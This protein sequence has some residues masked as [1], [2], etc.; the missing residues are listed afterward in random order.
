[1]RKCGVTGDG[2]APKSQ[3]P[4]RKKLALQYLPASYLLNPLSDGHIRNYAKRID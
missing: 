4:T 1:M 2:L 3:A